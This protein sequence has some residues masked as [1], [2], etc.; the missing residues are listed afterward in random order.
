M[1]LLSLRM[2]GKISGHHRCAEEIAGFDAV[3]AGGLG[4]D[5]DPAWV[6]Q[7]VEQCVACGGVDDRK[8]DDC[9]VQIC[10]F[11]VEDAGSAGSSIRCAHAWVEPAPPL[12]ASFSILVPSHQSCCLTDSPLPGLTAHHQCAIDWGR[13]S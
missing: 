3:D 4:G 8:F 5:S 11:A 9:P 2:S 12:F 13:R 6:Y 10:C 7:A 1:T